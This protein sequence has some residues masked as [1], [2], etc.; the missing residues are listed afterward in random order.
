MDEIIAGLARSPFVS[1]V[2][3]INRV[4]EPDLQVLY[5]K[6]RLTDDS[7]LYIRETITPHFDNYS[8]HWQTADNR[9]I[10]RW[11]N[12]AHWPSVATYPHHCHVGSQENVQPSE[13]PTIDEVIRYIAERLSAA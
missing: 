12:A 8:Y 2:E 7:V 1:E 6:A 11:D 10:C 4:D 3:V 5:L 13:H 9:I